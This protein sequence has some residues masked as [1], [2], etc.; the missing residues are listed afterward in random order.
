MRFKGVRQSKKRISYKHN[1]KESK[2]LI[3]GAFIENAR[4]RNNLLALRRK[5]KKR[6]PL[7]RLART[8]VHDVVKK[9][10]Y[11][12][13]INKLARNDYSNQLTNQ[14]KPFMD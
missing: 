7:R 9:H 14:L 12:T 1:L 5:T 6:Y 3:R 2:R 10:Y 8:S 11:S 13:L 4:G